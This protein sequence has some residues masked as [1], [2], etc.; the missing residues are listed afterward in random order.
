MVFSLVF[1]SL[2]FLSCFLHCLR[3]STVST[4]PRLL[5]VK[6]AK[7]LKFRESGSVNFG[8]Y[9]EYRLNTAHILLYNAFM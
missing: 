8:F 1:L 3:F 4:H 7:G 6:E 2:C 5:V 9:Y